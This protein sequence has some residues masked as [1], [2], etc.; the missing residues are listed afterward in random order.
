MQQK[1]PNEQF[2][3]YGD[4]AH[5]PYGDKSEEALQSYVEAILHYLHRRECKLVV[6]ACNSAATVIRNMK[7]LPFANENIVE[8]ISPIIELIAKQNKYVNIGII[9]TRKTIG[10]GM[11]NDTLSKQNPKLNIIARATPLL[12]PLIED[13]FMEESVLFP[14]FER[15]FKGFEH[16]ELLIPACTHYPIIYQQIERYFNYRLKVLHTPKIV[17]ESVEARLEYLKLANEQ[18]RHQNFDEFH[19]S[20]V[21]AEFVHSATF[22]LEKEVPFHRTL[23]PSIH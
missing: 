18:V 14:V 1:L 16:C 13:G 22:F 7:N 19:L 12:V 11:F 4:T 20:D 2:I 23:L 15:Y 10:S 21:T 8:V 9:G 6:V 17:A 5:L 3:Y